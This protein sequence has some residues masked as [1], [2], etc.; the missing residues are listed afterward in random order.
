V[1]T[2]DG[3]QKEERGRERGERERRFGEEERGDLEK[4]GRAGEQEERGQVGF[5]VGCGKTK[6]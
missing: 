4:R 2:P 5:K 6:T 1:Q 3:T